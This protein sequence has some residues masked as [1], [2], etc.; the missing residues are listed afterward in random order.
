MLKKVYG[1]EWAAAANRLPATAGDGADGAGNGGAGG[2]EA[3]GEEEAADG[4]SGEGGDGGGAR[5]PGGTYAGA[6]VD[7]WADP[8]PKV[9]REPIQGKGLRA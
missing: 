3:C 2:E 6:R 4:G 5:A 7:G 9:D 1:E 8:H